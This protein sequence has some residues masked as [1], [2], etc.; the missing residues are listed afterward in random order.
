MKR[1]KYARLLA[2]RLLPKTEVN[3][4]HH[5]REQLTRFLTTMLQQVKTL[6]KEICTKTLNPLFASNSGKS[7]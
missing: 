6:G 3:K 4:N 1:I 2:N 7:C 5:E